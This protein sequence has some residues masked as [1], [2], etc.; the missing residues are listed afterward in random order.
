MKSNALALE[1]QRDYVASRGDLNV[2]D[3]VNNPGASGKCRVFGL[4]FEE[5]PFDDFLREI[6]SL[7]QDCPDSPLVASN[8]SQPLAQ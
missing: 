5:Q 3:L 4:R 2:L 1:Y 7:G 6:R 8:P